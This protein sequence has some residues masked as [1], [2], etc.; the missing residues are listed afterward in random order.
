MPPEVLLIIF[1]TFFGIVGTILVSQRMQHRH[2]ERLQQGG[3][4]GSVEELR[5]AVEDLQEQV[6]AL[7]EGAAGFDERLEFTERLL[8]KPRST[9][10]QSS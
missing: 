2:A 8:A 9:G 3:D 6:H 10:A 1:G 4:S 7:Q 5:Q